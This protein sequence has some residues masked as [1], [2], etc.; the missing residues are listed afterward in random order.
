MYAA[1]LFHSTF[2]EASLAGIESYLTDMATDLIAIFAADNA[3]D[4]SV[5][6]P[7][8]VSVL[9]YSATHFHSTFRDGLLLGIKSQL[10]P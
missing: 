3:V 5:A 2:R 9:V 6:I 4:M 10:A 1:T 7:T 8:A